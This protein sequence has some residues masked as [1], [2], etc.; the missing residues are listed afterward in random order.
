MRRIV[1]GYI[2]HSA[3]IGALYCL[4]PTIAGFAILFAT[5]PFREV[6]VLRLA[7]SIAAGGSLAA[8]ANAR[9]TGLWLAK[10]RSPDGPATALD[11]PDR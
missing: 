11:A 5:V 2:R 6:Y 3:L 10:H 7:I 4:V 8:F 1:F 9:G